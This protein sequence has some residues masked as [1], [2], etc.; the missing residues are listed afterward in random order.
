[1]KPTHTRLPILYTF[2]AGLLL[3][4]CKV[5][6]GEARPDGVEA[7]S[8]GANTTM[9]DS[10]AS[11][12]LP[13]DGA[14]SKQGDATKLASADTLQ[15]HSLQNPKDAPHD[16]RDI[17]KDV[18]A[19]IPA[20]RNISLEVPDASGAEL[21]RMLGRAC[22]LNVIVDESLER[23]GALELKNVSARDAF[24]AFARRFDVR[25]ERQ[26]GVLMMSDARAPRRV[27]KLIQ[28]SISDFTNLDEK[29]KTILGDSGSFSISAQARTVFVEGTE[30]RVAQAEKLF[31]NLALEER[32]VVIEARIFEITFD[33]RL[34]FGVS[35]DHLLDVGESTLHIL[36]T[37]LPESNN[38]GVTAANRPE[39]LTSTM[40][41]LRK[42]SSVELLSSPRVAT[43]N[44]KDASI[45]V[46]QEVPYIQTTNSV[47]Q[48]TAGGSTSTF[49]QVEF[50]EAG[51]S[52]KVKPT[53]LSDGSVRLDVNTKVSQVASFFINIPVIDKR[54]L[55]SIVFLADGGTIFLG[56]LMQRSVTDI[57]KKVPIL[58]DIP[59]LGYLFKSID[60]QVKRKELLVLLTTRVMD[61][62]ADPRITNEYKERFRDEKSDI[63]RK[64][65][66]TRLSDGDV[67]AAK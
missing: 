7:R 11:V 15:N 39:T 6:R 34:E 4:S 64:R 55:Q 45:D 59:L 12:V 63:E 58:G 18:E 52:L 67:P 48:T 19:L 20:D 8:T 24:A 65:G 61:G 44:G 21:A 62:P 32:Q 54:T 46:I 14:P 53:I 43:L 51:I 31:L 13:V 38:F 56:G 22:D 36:Q 30:D 25:V 47:S 37:L 1:M 10:Q 60:Q 35:H 28:V 16:P 9:Q 26:G 57:E 23:K 40:Q 2:A 66:G 41:A 5:T 3:A 49:Q 33:D 27:S 42:L 29:L 50:K 17:T